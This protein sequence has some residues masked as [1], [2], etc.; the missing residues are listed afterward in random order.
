[1]INMARMKPKGARGRAAVRRLGRTYATGGFA[2]IAAKA[3]GGAKGKRI[4]G[5]IF[6][7]MARARKG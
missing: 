6:Q 7:K 1:V 5:A 4:A 2:K 3:G